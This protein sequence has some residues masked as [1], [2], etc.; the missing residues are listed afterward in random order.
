MTTMTELTVAELS[1]LY[2]KVA[3]DDD[4]RRIVEDELADRDRAAAAKRKAVQARRADPVVNEWLD[5]A[6][7]QYM[8]AEAQCAGKLVRN[9]SV[10]TDAWALWSGPEWLARQCATEE[11]Q[12]FWDDHPRIP[13]QTAWRDHQR[14]DVPPDEENQEETMGIAG[15]IGRA[16]GHVARDAGRVAGRATEMSVRESLYAARRQAVTTSVQ[17]AANELAVTEPGSA[18]VRSREPV[19]GDQ[20]LRYI[21]TFLKRF[22]VW[23][24]DAEVVAATLWIA[25]THARD[26]NGMPIWQYCA[27][28]LITGPSGSGKSWKSRLVGKLSFKGKILVEPTKPAFIDICAENHTVIITESDETF[29][30]PGRSRSLVAVMNASYEPDRESSRKQGGVHVDIPLF[31]HA[32]LDGI[33]KIMLSPTRPDLVAMTSRCIVLMARKAREGYR[34]PRFDKRARAM[35]NLLSQRAGAW[36]AQEVDNALEDEVPDVPDHLGNRPFALW[37][38]LFA[39]AKR[40]DECAARRDG[41]TDGGDKLWSSACWLACEQLEATFAATQPADED[42]DELDQQMAAWADAMQDTEEE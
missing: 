35:A 40:A 20:V 23:G 18:V 19:D 33:D 3:H 26:A 6:H 8:Q 28:L 22:A 39:V 4:A 2:G 24:S 5:A 36:M 31:C 38:P 25:Q 17:H 16:A 15:E 29:R 32:V 14:G 37:E 41:R 11:L 9:G 21:Y 30:S 27:R 10:I 13:T 34:P 1:E 7:A 12:N 42:L